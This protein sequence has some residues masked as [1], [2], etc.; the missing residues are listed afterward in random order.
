MS[1]SLGFD[2]VAS[3]TDGQ[4]NQERHLVT[5][6]SQYDKENV[7]PMSRADARDMKK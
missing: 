1:S 7:H 3:R 2:V 4:P 5:F 6:D